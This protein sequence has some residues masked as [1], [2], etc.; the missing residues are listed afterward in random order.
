MS[1]MIEIAIALGLNELIN[2]RTPPYLFIY[3]LAYILTVQLL[4][5]LP[6]M[7]QKLLLSRLRKFRMAS[8]FFSYY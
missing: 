2:T 7:F 8:V 3:I 5:G 4:M 1:V 6:Q